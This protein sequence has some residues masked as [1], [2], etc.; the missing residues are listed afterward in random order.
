[1]TEVFADSFYFIALLNKRDQHH[2]VACEMARQNF[3]RIVTTHWV[4]VETINALSAR[5]LRAIAH[6]FAVAAL[7][8]ASLQVISE[9]HWFERGLDLFGNRPDK[10]WSLTDRISFAVMRDR[11]VTHTLTGDRHYAQAGYV[12]LFA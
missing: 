2:R 4:L 7:A 1:M 9:R 8:D 11:G 10:D 3:H 12:P 6:D 5:P